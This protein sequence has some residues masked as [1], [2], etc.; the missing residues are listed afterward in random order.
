M[1]EIAYGRFE[2]LLT[3]PKG[4]DSSQV[5]ASYQHGVLELTMPASPEV[6]GRKIPVEVGMQDNKQ[7][8]HQA[9]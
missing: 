7:L 2:R 6:T 4:I 3:L 1:R 5:K 9:A 8:E